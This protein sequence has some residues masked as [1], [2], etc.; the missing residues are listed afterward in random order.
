M[1]SE[2]Y[3]LIPPS[4]QNNF[5]PRRGESP[6]DPEYARV[7][8]QKFHE[9]QEEI[10]RL[11]L[12]I[13]NKEKTPYS[14]SVHLNDF[15]TSVE[16]DEVIVKP[17]L[18]G[19][20]IYTFRNVGI[21]FA[22]PLAGWSL[23][24]H[25]KLQRITEVGDAPYHILVPGILE[26]ELLETYNRRRRNIPGLIGPMSIFEELHT[27]YVFSPD[28]SFGKAINSFPALE[29]AEN[30][31]LAANDVKTLLVAKPMF[32]RDFEVCGAILTATLDQVRVI[33]QGLSTGQS[34]S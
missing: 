3:D 12:E 28:G 11:S 16:P 25:G 15:Y 9:W 13:F 10:M 30:I 24:W 18:D 21:Y 4:G 26:Q 17:R 2:D 22:Q 20:N 32:G 19:L 23:E 6:V 29:T 7:L 34:P 14:S 33:H 27:E 31:P 8:S 5:P 1:S